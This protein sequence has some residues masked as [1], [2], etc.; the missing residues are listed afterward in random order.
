MNFVE[1]HIFFIS[2]FHMKAK[3]GLEIESED[4]K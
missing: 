4:M 1:S 2:G 3:A